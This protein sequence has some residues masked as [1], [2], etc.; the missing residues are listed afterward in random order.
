M[1][2]QSGF[3]VRS[4]PSEGPAASIDFTDKARIVM[5]SFPEVA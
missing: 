5:A 3:E 1:R 2:A 4:A